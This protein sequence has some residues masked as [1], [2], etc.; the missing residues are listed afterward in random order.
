MNRLI[1][2][3]TGDVLDVVATA[4]IR[5]PGDA[6]PVGSDGDPDE[7]FVVDA[8][9]IHEQ[10][11]AGGPPYVRRTVKPWRT[12]E[13]HLGGYRRTLHFG[14]QV[15]GVVG[16]ALQLTTADGKMTT[17]LLPWDPSYD[18]P[19]TDLRVFRSDSEGNLRSPRA[20][21]I[22]RFVV[23]GSGHD[24]P[25]A[26]RSFIVGDCMAFASLAYVGEIPGH[27]YRVLRSPED[28][29][30]EGVLRFAYTIPHADRRLRG[31]ILLAGLDAALKTDAGEAARFEIHGFVLPTPPAA[32]EG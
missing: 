29:A 26:I 8:E 19:F 14:P 12:C 23:F 32:V 30:L 27:D 11:I 21:R 17:I 24:G 15:R 13:L 2:D 25:P 18:G 4:H 22:D 6:D 10:D 7:T 16:A 20:I 1:C 5:T 3:V 28:D 9:G 31:S